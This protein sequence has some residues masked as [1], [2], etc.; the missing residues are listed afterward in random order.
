MYTEYFMVS[1]DVNGS[2]LEYQLRAGGETEG[3][4]LSLICTG[5]SCV[6][7]RASVMERCG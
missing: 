5:M 7:V 3:S 2:R 6:N 1:A 4:R